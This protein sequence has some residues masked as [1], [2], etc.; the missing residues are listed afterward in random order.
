MS[1]SEKQRLVFDGEHPTVIM[2]L[3]TAWCPPCKKFKP[4]RNSLLQQHNIFNVKHGSKIDYRLFEQ[5]EHDV[6]QKAFGIK[7]YP[8][9]LVYSPKMNSFA[10]YRGRHEA[11]DITDFAFAF[12]NKTLTPAPEIWNTTPKFV[13]M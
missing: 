6:V 4:Q 3:A 11:S 12:H 9:I 13:N 1:F 5:G 10:K 8:T 2:H 7:G